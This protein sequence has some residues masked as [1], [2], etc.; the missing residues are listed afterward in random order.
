MTAV[1]QLWVC[2]RHAPPEFLPRESPAPPPLPLSP[3]LDE[4]PTP[5]ALPL[6]EWLREPNPFVALHRLTDAAEL[7][8]RFL[9]IVALCDVVRQVGEVPPSLQG[10]L[11]DR[12]GTP[13]F[14]AWRELGSS[15]LRT[16]AERRLG[17]FLRLLAL[18]IV[19]VELARHALLQPGD[20][21]GEHRLAVARQLLLG[22]EEV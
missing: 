8:T 17:C 11:A 21:L 10:E 16:L 15:A 7:I 18:D 6:A 13:T 12:L 1:D 3:L 20:A 2:G 14:G 5:L 4:L 19:L 9:A 22:V